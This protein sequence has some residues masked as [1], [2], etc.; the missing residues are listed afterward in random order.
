MFNNKDIVKKTF[1]EAAPQFDEIGTPFFRYFGE[2]LADFSEAGNTDHILD[3]AC[4]KGATTFSLLKKI[5]GGGKIDAI[6]ISPN[7]IEECK[8]NFFS[9]DGCRT[10]SIYGPLNG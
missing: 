8:K 5:T 6:D 4:G 2:K 7:M 10:T 9:C 3:V 1:D